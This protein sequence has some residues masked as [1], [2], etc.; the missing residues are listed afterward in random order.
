MKHLFLGG[1]GDGEW[2]EVPD[3][4]SHWRLARKAD[5]DSPHL[6]SGDFIPGFADISLVESAYKRARLIDSDQTEWV[7]FID[8]DSNLKA[9]SKLIMGYQGAKS[10][11]DKQSH[12]L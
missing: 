1:C 7:V 2:I 10:S 12:G 4:T 6:V 3:G 11:R 5:R 8:I 9:V